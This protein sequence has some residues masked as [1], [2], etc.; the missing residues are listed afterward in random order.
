MLKLPLY[1]K[2]IIQKMISKL[3][4]RPHQKKK[5]LFSRQPFLYTLCNPTLSSFCLQ[6]PVSHPEMPGVNELHDKTS[7]GSEEQDKK[8]MLCLHS[9]LVSL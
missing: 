3:D 1:K 9:Y 7:C 5:V 2:L 4:T 6:E 8:C